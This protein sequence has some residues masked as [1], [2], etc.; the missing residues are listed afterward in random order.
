[1]PS[2][3]VV[4]RLFELCFASSLLTGTVAVAQMNSGAIAG[5][6]KDQLEGVVAGATVVAEQ[7]GTRQKFA[8]T[9]NEAGAYLLAQLPV[10][11]YV[12]SVSSPNFRDAVLPKLDVH[13]GDSLRF[14][15]TLQLGK[16]GEIVDIG[17]PE[18]TAR[19]AV[20]LLRDTAAWQ[21]AQRAGAERVS[22]YYNEE[23]MITRYREIYQKATA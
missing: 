22:R 9:S 8:T 6:V 14:D 16:A 7:V 12:L 23:Q 15:F 1:M 5:T 21:R 10:G 2:R 18:A 3:R 4:S 17:N 11:S 13:V 20:A 19:A